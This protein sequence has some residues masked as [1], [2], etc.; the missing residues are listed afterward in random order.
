MVCHRFFLFSE[1]SKSQRPSATNSFLPKEFFS[2]LV[3]TLCPTFRSVEE[4]RFHYRLVFVYL[5]FPC[6]FFD[7]S[8]PVQCLPNACEIR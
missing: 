1:D 4:N 5:G 6:Q 8:Y 3:Y 7:F 2:R